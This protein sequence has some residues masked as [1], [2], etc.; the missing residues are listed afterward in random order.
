MSHAIDKFPIPRCFI[1][2]VY[3][4][5]LVEV[6]TDIS[7]GRFISEIAAVTQLLQKRNVYKFLTVISAAIVQVG[8]LGHFIHISIT[9]APVVS[10]FKINII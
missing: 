6:P 7:G 9:T 1:T 4:L 5:S 2:H 3:I 10:A 8:P